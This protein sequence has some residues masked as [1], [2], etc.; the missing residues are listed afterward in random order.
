MLH[1]LSH[2]V[3]DALLNDPAT[4]MSRHPD[5]PWKILQ[6]LHFH[7][8]QGGRTSPTYSHLRELFQL[9][10]FASG[11]SLGTWQEEEAAGSKW[12]R[13]HV[14]HSI[15]AHKGLV[16]SIGLYPPRVCSLHSM[17]RTWQRKALGTQSSFWN[18]SKHWRQNFSGLMANGL[19][20]SFTG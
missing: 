11:D 6:Y 7:W 3:P 2:V 20:D 12:Q 16:C 8:C 15:V 10:S 14:S 1:M 18:G 17:Y 19:C 5:H 13:D 4:W 9:E